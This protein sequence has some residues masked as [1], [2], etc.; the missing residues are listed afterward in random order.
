MTAPNEVIGK[1][2]IPGNPLDGVRCAL[3]YQNASGTV[4]ILRDTHLAAYRWGDSVKVGPGE[5]ERETA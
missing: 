2:R 4:V 1:I 3:W 5:F